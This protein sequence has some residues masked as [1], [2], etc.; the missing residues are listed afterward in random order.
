MTTLTWSGDTTYPH[1]NQLAGSTRVDLYPVIALKRGRNITFRSEVTL[2]EYRRGHRMTMHHMAVVDCF[3]FQVIDMGRTRSDSHK[4]RVRTEIPVPDFYYWSNGQNIGGHQDPPAGP[5]YET[6]DVTKNVKSRYPDHYHILGMTERGNIARRI[7]IEGAPG[8]A[9]VHHDCRMNIYDC[10]YYKFRGAGVISE[11]GSEVGV[12]ARNLAIDAKPILQLNASLGVGL[13]TYEGTAATGGDNHRFGIGFGHASR[14]VQLFDNV[15]VGCTF[16]ENFYHRYNFGTTNR[17][18]QRANPLRAQVD[19]KDLNLYDQPIAGTSDTTIDF[20]D[21]PLIGVMEQE[22]IA[23]FDSL[24][25]SKEVARQGHDVNVN[26]RGWKSWGCVGYG[27]TIEYVYTYIMQDFD[28]VAGVKATTRAGLE[29]GGNTYSVAAR[30][31]RSEGFTYALG[32]YGKTDTMG[33]D[34]VEFEGHNA[35]SVN[36]PRFIQ[37]SIDDVDCTNFLEADKP[38]FNK[39]YLNNMAVWQRTRRS[40]RR[41][42]LVPAGR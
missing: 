27:A 38:S 35:S 23:C 42:R 2:P 5:I 15:T 24:F 22:H 28:L 10:V 19:L 29:F 40:L 32:Q 25:V 9:Q 3:D 18:T 20:R 21:Y 13:K 17:V 30:N 31:L 39:L 41:H 12:W 7:Y 4:G 6:L 1:N 36:D 14:A 11:Q 8:H 37:Y 26:F 34:N 16:G 33:S